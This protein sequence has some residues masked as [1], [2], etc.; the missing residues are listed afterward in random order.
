MHALIERFVSDLRL[1]DDGAIRFRGAVVHTPSPE[2]ANDPDRRRLALTECTYKFLYTHPDGR[3]GEAFRQV[4]EDEALMSAF[5]EID[6]S[7]AKNRTGWVV[8]N[9]MPDGSIIASRFAKMQKFLPGQYIV[10]PDRIPVRQG[11]EVSVIPRTK[12]RTQQPGFF[13]FFSRASLDLAE[14]PPM[15][16]LYWNVRRD[17]A[18]DLVKT[19]ID[20]LNAQDIA[21]NFKIATRACDYSRTDCAVLYLPRRMF[22]VAALTLAPK[23]SRLSA[24]LHAREPAF[25]R[26]LLPGVGLAEDPGAAMHSFGSSRCEILADSILAAKTDD[27]VPLDRFRD[28]FAAALQSRGLRMDALFLNPRSEDIYDV[29][30][31]WHRD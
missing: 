24:L 18:V 23:I 10:E 26:R 21:F 31:I 2:A 19:L 14:L 27:H 3:I 30:D 29:S 17:G 20:T 1:D 15:V 9:A 22:R 28:R 16:R 5:S 12:S 25:T 6:N 13:F 4:P 7:P 8:E 11:T